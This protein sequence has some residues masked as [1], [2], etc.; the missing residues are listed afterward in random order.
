MGVKENIEKVKLNLINAAKKSGREP[1]EI[2]II[3]VTKYV[4]IELIK[5]VN[6]CGIGSFGESKVQD[7]C[8]KYEQ[9]GKGYNWH[10][11][12]R[13]QKNKVKYI[14]D[15][16][17]LIHS[18]DTIE[19]LEELEKRATLLGKNVNVLIQVNI[20]GEDTKQGLEE[21]MLEEFLKEVALFNRIRVLGLMTIAPFVENPEHIRSIFRE[22]K[23]TF[24][25]IKKLN[26][27]NVD[28]KYLSMGMSNDYEIAIEEGANL[29]RV[30]RIL[31]K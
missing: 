11:I 12:G 3:A 2:N 18:V 6:E 26:L 13:L 8:K 14:I 22:L 17:D 27:K 10:F 29:I 16:V 28:M 19:L 1:S 23:N 24:E 7:F 4:D 25:Q 20:S 5:L 9:L 15:K 31:F 21:N 30:G